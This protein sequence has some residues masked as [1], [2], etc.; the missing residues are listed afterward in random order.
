MTD[1]TLSPPTLAAIL[2]NAQPSRFS[3]PPPDNYCTVPKSPLEKHQNGSPLHVLPS[4][5][6]PALHAHAYD[7]TELLHA[8]LTSQL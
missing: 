6:Y 3:A 5:E 7:P 8:A 1:F 2:C 4:P